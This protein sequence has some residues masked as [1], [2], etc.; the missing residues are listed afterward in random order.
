M[1]PI[2][3]QRLRLPG[4]L[5]ALLSLGVAGIAVAGPRVDAFSGLVAAE[6][7]FAADAGRLGIGAAFLAHVAA[8]GILL[9][10]APVPARPALSADKND[11]GVVLEW[12]PA[13]ALIAQSGDFGVTTGPYRLA[14][15]GKAS[16]GQFLTVWIRDRA[17][18]WHWFLDHG[19]PPAPGDLAAPLPQTV[20]RLA[21][22]KSAAGTD[23]AQA[24]DRLN[25]AVLNGE[26][27]AQFATLAADARLLRPRHAPVPSAEAKAALAA[28]A[29][30]TAV[31]RLGMRVARTGDLGVTYG[32]VTSAGGKDSTYV[33]IWRR[34]ATGWRVVIDE[35]T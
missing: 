1:K 24:D 23:P 2:L 27:D 9:R 16:H 26:G 18:R 20:E 25:D 10:P 7:R 31:A 19:L 6:R 22:G 13:T 8:D 35:R 5:L 11:P 15:A 3:R 34:D 4:A 17:G 12:Q 21:A 32:K 28:D 30:A 29:L 14:A 33:R